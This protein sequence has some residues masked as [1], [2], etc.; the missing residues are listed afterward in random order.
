M[1]RT[2][3][4]AIA[5]IC[6]VA[7]CSDSVSVKDV[8]RDYD[9]VSIIVSEDQFGVYNHTDHS[10]YFMVVD[11]MLEAMIIWF[12]ESTAENR[13]QPGERRK[14]HLEDVHAYQPGNRVNFHYW[15]DED[16]EP[17]TLQLIV[18]DPESRSSE[19]VR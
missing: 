14:F 17:E 19:K 9:G 16:P 4:L 10:L 6:T 3:Y 5:V 12:P 11:R 7:A 2:F 18:V 1:N 13:I 8:V 15:F